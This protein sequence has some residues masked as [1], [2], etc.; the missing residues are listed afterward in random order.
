MLRKKHSSS[1]L[2]PVVNKFPASKV[3]SPREE[4]FAKRHRPRPPARITTRSTSSHIESNFLGPAEPTDRKDFLTETLSQTE[5]IS[6]TP[7]QPPSPRIFKSPRSPKR[8]NPKQ[9][10]FPSGCLPLRQYTHSKKAGNHH[11]RK[12]PKRCI[13][14]LEDSERNHDTR[15]SRKASTPQVSKT[16]KENRNSY[17]FGPPPKQVPENT[18]REN[19]LKELCKQVRPI[20]LHDVGH[21]YEM[22]HP[23]HRNYTKVGESSALLNRNKDLNSKC[24]P[25]KKFEIANAASHQKIPYYKRIER[26]IHIEL[27]NHR[28]HLRCLCNDEHREWFFS[29]DEGYVSNIVAKWRAWSRLEPYDAFCL[30]RMWQDAWGYYIRYPKRYD[31]MMKKQ[32]EGWRWNVFLEGVP[33]EFTEDNKRVAGDTK[34]LGWEYQYVSLDDEAHVRDGAKGFF[35]MLI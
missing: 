29:S 27:S 5:K 12:G 14:P 30:K 34:V 6:A 9:T 22:T 26:I 4:R 7:K 32:N 24:F 15:A 16:R 8:N 35:G 23:N 17:T 1:Y 21:V 33:R 25:D 18:I 3:R 19:I 31:A 13:T 28:R 20:D 2:E 10:A 11:D